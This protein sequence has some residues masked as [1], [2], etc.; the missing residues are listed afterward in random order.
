MDKIR[1]FDPWVEGQQ[2]L[3]RYAIHQGNPPQGIAANY[4]VEDILRCVR[5]NAGAFLL[6]QFVAVS[7]VTFLEG[8]AVPYVVGHGG[9]FQLQG[10]EVGV[11][12]L[13]KGVDQQSRAAAIENGGQL[14]ELVIGAGTGKFPFAP[15]DP[16]ALSQI[17]HVVAAEGNLVESYLPLIG[18]GI[19]G[20]VVGPDIIFVAHRGQQH[21]YHLRQYRG[22]PLS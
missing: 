10:G 14:F 16:A 4:G 20:R 2:V 6:C 17:L 18:N 1:V 19:G 13:P 5:C 3:Q 11:G 21:G 9:L 7:V 15:H 12:N 8:K 22:K